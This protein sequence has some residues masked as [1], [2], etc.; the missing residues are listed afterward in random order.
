VAGVAADGR[1]G[2]RASGCANAD[3]SGM[4]R[5]RRDVARP[6]VVRAA[7]VQALP[8]LYL[9]GLGAE[10]EA[11]GRPVKE[12]LDRAINHPLMR[13]SPEVRGYGVVTRALQ[14]SSRLR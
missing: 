1:S 14:P 8:E 10:A 9:S 4:R 12:L 3:E 11:G 2:L 13:S 5:L 7:A 6:G